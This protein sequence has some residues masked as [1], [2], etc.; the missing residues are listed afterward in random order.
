MKCISNRHCFSRR[1]LWRKTGLHGKQIKW[2]KN[3]SHQGTKAESS[4]NLG[5]ILLK[6]DDNSYSHGRPRC[7]RM[8][9]LYSYL[10]HTTLQSWHMLPYLNLTITHECTLL[11]FLHYWGQ[12]SSS[13]VKQL[14]K[15]WNTI[16]LEELT[17]ALFEDR[18]HLRNMPGDGSKTPQK[19]LTCI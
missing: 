8:I 19:V 17:S 2:K 9:T 3:T 14:A 10:E 1:G 16:N 4:G 15:C 18:T 5:N 6:L 7:P 13:E 12:W 11:S